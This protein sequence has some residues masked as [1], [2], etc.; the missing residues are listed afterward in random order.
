MGALLPSEGKF[1]SAIEPSDTKAQIINRRI[2]TKTVRTCH[3]RET[4]FSL[5]PSHIKVKFNST[6]EKMTEFAK[7]DALSLHRN[8]AE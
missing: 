1:K 8:L 4:F 2:L 7:A 3:G 5:S 6:F